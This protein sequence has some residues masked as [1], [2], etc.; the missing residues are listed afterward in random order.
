M[1]FIVTL[2]DNHT[3]SLHITETSRLHF[4]F[5]GASVLSCIRHH[6]RRSNRL[7]SQAPLLFQF[8]FPTPYMATTCRAEA[9]MLPSNYSSITS[10]TPSTS[11]VPGHGMSRRCC[12]VGSEFVKRIL[13]F[14]F[15][16]TASHRTSIN[17]RVGNAYSVSSVM[18]WKL[19]ITH[20]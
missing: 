13:R 19:S 7:S 9:H 14:F 3:S 16:C 12:N 4:T 20:T 1:F 2:S 8:H 11:F 5:I 17:S 15:M 10:A 6:T 18:A